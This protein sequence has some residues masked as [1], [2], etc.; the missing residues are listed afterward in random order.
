[1]TSTPTLVVL[2]LIAAA[3]V[4]LVARMAMRKGPDPED[5]RLPIAIDG[6]GVI[7]YTDFLTRREAEDL[8][9]KLNAVRLAVWQKLQHIYGRKCGFNFGRINLNH[10]YTYDGRPVPVKLFR[11]RGV[12]NLRPQ[13]GNGHPAE[14]WFAL[15]L[16]NLYRGWAL[17]M[18]RYR[19]RGPEDIARFDRATKACVQVAARFAGPV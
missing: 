15:E 19:P 17:G 8:A 7:H 2:L 9:E 11:A 1:M 4:V 14:F 16:H 5:A 18:D 12:M 13:G 6:L 10:N 3:V